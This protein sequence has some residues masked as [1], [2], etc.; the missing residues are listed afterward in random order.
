M[1]Q[2]DVR[3]LAVTF[4]RLLRQR[5]TATEIEKVNKINQNGSGVC[6]SHDFLDADLTMKEA[7]QIV[8][9][10]VPDMTVKLDNT[11]Y[12]NAWSFAF[13]SEFAPY[14]GEEAYN[15]LNHIIQ[16]ILTFDDY[17]QPVA[18]A[19]EFIKQ[20]ENLYKFKPNN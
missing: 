11:L 20:N 9:F 12:N 15:L 10:R 17:N 5:L 18:E 3:L 6:G 13:I 4:S 7:F 16:P 14:N 1:K 19:T 8:F 2:S